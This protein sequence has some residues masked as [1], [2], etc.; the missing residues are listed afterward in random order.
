MNVRFEWDEDKAR[1]NKQKHGITFETAMAV[2]EDPYAYVEQDRFE[3]GEYRWRTIGTV[4]G[5]RIVLVAH[6]NYFEQRT[7]VIRIISA[8]GATKQERKIY[9]ND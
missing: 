7:E 4:S 6:V 9:G 5:E 1:L 2:F 3:N 8:R